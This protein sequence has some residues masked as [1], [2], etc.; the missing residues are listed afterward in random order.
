MTTC[1]ANNNHRYHPHHH[2]RLTASSIP[3]PLFLQA[4]QSVNI[5][6]ATI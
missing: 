1:Q 4:I 6:I 3:F 5:Q 2:R